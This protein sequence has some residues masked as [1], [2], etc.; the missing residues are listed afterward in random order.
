MTVSNSAVS[1]VSAVSSAVESAF[2]FECSKQ[3]L[4]GPEGV[5]TP[6]Y[7][8]F[9]SDNW[10]TVGNTCSSRYV[11]HTT[12]DVKA[13]A[14]ACSH[15]YDHDVN[16]N[17]HFRDGHHVTMAP[18]NA[19]MLKVYGSDVVFPRIAIAFRYDGKACKASMALFRPICKNM[20]MFHTVKSCH[21]S[22]RHTSNLRNQMDSLIDTFSNLRNSW[23][24]LSA[25]IETMESR[26]VRMTEFLDSVY[27]PAPTESGRGRTQHE[28]R[29]RAIFER[30]ERERMQTGRGLMTRANN[31]QV[32]GWE[33]YNAIQGYHQHTATRKTGF[34]NMA[35]RIISTANATPVKTAEKLI[36]EMSA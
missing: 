12:D 27:G 16:I 11:P 24:D 2:P 3:R 14:E 4:T 28:N 9:R 25:V 20:E 35:D 21:V 36:L 15:A 32:S 34:D 30:L 26:S 17:C 1:A 7:G 19:E 18:T 31:F 33:A 22:I 8:I 5:Q 13:L 23:T 6:F 29:T 10:E